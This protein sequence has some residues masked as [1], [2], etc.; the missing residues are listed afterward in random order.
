MSPAK[1][2]FLVWAAFIIGG[3]GNNRGMLIGAMV[4]TLTEFLFNVLVAAQSSPDLALGDTAKVIDENFVWMIESPLEISS[5][6][7]LF[8]IILFVFKRYNFLKHYSGFHSYLWHV[9]LCLIN[10]Q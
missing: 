4:I 7:L 1:S 8:S 9:I 3:A 5:Y 6:F 2:T 10:V